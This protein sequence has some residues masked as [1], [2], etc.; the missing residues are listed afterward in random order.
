[1]LSQWSEDAAG[2]KVDGDGLISSGESSG[3][4]RSPPMVGDWA[5]HFDLQLSPGAPA[6]V[7]MVDERDRSTEV[8][9]PL[10]AD[11]IAELLVP[12]GPRVTIDPAAQRA[13]RPGWNDVRLRFAGGRLNL[14][15][16]GWPAVEDWPAR[17]A[18]GSLRLV[19]DAGSGASPRRL[20]YVRFAQRSGR[21]E[22][23]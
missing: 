2:W 15:L 14:T 7:A 1:V 20:R 18:P 10:P 13:L 16:N 22:R 9:L 4:L 5:I 12:D 6:V 21:E 19:F 3:P 11:G 23:P 8:R 17:E